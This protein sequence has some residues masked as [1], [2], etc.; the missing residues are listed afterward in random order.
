MLQ[1]YSS[2]RE[3]FE[4]EIINL[5]DHEVRYCTGCAFCMEKGKCWIDDDHRG[6]TDRLLDCPRRRPGLPGLL[7]SSVTG[8]MKTFMDRSLAFGPQT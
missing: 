4:L 3:G 2:P 8:Q 1:Y 5:S 7:F 6:V